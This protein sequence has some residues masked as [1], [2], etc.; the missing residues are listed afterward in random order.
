MN[1]KAYQGHSPNAARDAVIFREATT[2]GRTTAELMA[3]YGLGE[4]RILQIVRMGKLRADRDKLR[5]Q[6]GL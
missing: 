4:T 2:E 6:T 3:K 5:E 1:Q